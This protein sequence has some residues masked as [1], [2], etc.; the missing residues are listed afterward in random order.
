MY[1]ESE[2]AVIS[3]KLIDKLSTSSSKFCR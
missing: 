1:I 2:E 3:A